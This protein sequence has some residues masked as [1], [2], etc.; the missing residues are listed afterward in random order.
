MKEQLSDPEHEKMLDNADNYATNEAYEGHLKIGFSHEEAL[1]S[2]GVK[3][4]AIDE[5]GKGEDAY[6]DNDS[7]NDFS[8]MKSMFH[9]LR[10]S[11]LTNDETIDEIVRMFS[12]PKE[13]VAQILGEYLLENFATEDNSYLESLSTEV[14]N[15]LYA[16]TSR[17]TGNHP[18]PQVLKT[19]ESI[20]A[21]RAK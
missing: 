17:A 16:T 12:Q 2:L 5:N 11:N 6:F 9:A 18:P 20:L 10:Y 3:E 21:K 13:K 19:I 1:R 8:E 7:E 14:L 15:K 4:V